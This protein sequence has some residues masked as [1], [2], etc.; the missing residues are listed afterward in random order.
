MT[1]RS[2]LACALFAGLLAGCSHSNPAEPSASGATITGSIVA[3]SAG[4]GSTAGMSANSA[5][6]S[7][8]ST[9]PPG[10][11]VSVAGTANSAS[12]DA[13]G[14]FTLKDVPPGLASLQF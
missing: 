13:A 6:I 12:V 2:L 10:L 8:A 14:Q 4:N 1:H 5:S 9:T 3:A 7:A 11:L